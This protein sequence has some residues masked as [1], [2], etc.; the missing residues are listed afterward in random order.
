MK[1]LVKLTSFG[2]ILCALFVVETLA[3][4]AQVQPQQEPGPISAP[5]VTLNIQRSSG[6]CPQTIGLWWFVLP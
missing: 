4:T 1:N 2:T 3:A 5:N 6:T